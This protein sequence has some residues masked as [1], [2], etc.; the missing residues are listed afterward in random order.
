MSEQETLK[1]NKPNPRII[2][3]I[4]LLGFI[5]LMV[6]FLIKKDIDSSAA[7]YIGVPMILAIGLSRLPHAKTP[8]GTTMKALTMLLIL[9]VPLLREGF[10]CIIMA[11]PILYSAAALFTLLF[12]KIRKAD[13]H[14]NKMQLSAITVLLTLTSVEGIDESLSFNRYNE[15]EYTTTVNLDITTIREN[16]SKATIPT[17][18]RPFFLRVFPLPIDMQGSGLDVGDERVLN[19]E[20]KKW[21]VTNMHK[22]STVFKITSATQNH[23]RFEIPHDD[24]YISNYL[25]WHASDVFLEPVDN[26]ATNVTWRL[27][28]ERKLD[29]FW[30]FAPLQHYATYLTAKVLTDNV[31][32][33]HK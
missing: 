6:Y 4:L 17:D 29:P 32:A 9:S 25:T 12:Q 8:M 11:A 16:L 18:K 30:Y 24:S 15:V 10:V 14:S 23:I 19:Y 7:L 26:G 21:I 27:S 20:Y 5:Y 13:N 31:V 33:E 22:G 2:F 1:N 28:Y 3:F